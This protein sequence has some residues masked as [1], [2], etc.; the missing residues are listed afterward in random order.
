MLFSHLA[1]HISSRRIL[2]RKLRKFRILHSIQG[3]HSTEQLL[4]KGLWIRQ[5][6]IFSM[7]ANISLQQNVFAFGSTHQTAF[8]VIES[9]CAEDLEQLFD[10]GESTFQIC[11]DSK[12]EFFPERSSY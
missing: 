11:A 5:I 3:N 7:H 10:P 9:N 12:F 6:W 2:I 1:T 8:Y 4:S